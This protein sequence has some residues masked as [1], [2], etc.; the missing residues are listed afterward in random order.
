MPLESTLKNVS[1]ARSQCCHCRVTLV[2]LS[3]SNLL[4]SF[5][6]LHLALKQSF[7]H[8]PLGTLWFSG[9]HLHMWWFLLSLSKCCFTLTDS[10]AIRPIQGGRLSE[11]EINSSLITWVLACSHTFCATTSSSSGISKTDFVKMDASAVVASSSPLCCLPC[12]ADGIFWKFRQKPI[13]TEIKYGWI[14][15]KNK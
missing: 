6:V 2:S 7:P 13:K 14:Q 9:T 11:T 8:C 3:S 15:N 12:A 4:W 1:Q 5:A 10:A